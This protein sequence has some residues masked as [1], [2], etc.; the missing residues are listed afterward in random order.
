MA[1]VPLFFFGVFVT[2]LV[3]LGV[4]F[5]V[6]EFNQSHVPNDHLEDSRPLSHQ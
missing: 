4:V 6:M 3:A 1:D 2:L 5:A